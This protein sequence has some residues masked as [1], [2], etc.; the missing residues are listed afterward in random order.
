L[1]LIVWDIDDVLND[2]MRCWFEDLEPGTRQKIKFED[3]TCNPPY[4]NLGISKNAFLNSLDNFRVSEKGRNLA[5]N[6][7][8]LEWFR[9]DG[10]RFR[11]LALTARPRRSMPFLAEWVFRHFGHWIRTVSFVPSFREG[12]DL[13]VYDVSKSEFLGWLQRADFYIDDIPENVKAAE[14]MGIKGFEYPQPWNKGMLT[15][16]EILCRLS[17]FA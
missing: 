17:Q 3:L 5:P 1:K 8:I 2:L 6:P 12:E 9:S 16:D 15:A 14:M 10:S 13:P 11:H 7:R 4:E